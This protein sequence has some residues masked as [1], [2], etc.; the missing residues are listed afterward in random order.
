MVR[1]LKDLRHQN[2]ISARDAKITLIETGVLKL[3]NNIKNMSENEVKSK[4][5]DL[6][7]NIVEKIIDANK[8]LHM[9]ELE[10]EKFT[11]QRK[12]QQG[13]RSKILTPNQM[14]IT[15]PALLARLKAGK[16]SE[17]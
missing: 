13:Q 15:L 11:E 8:L 16:N 5:L 10:T 1:Q 6:L 4:G 9:P 17:K 12:N 3:K 14:I 7:K 2:K